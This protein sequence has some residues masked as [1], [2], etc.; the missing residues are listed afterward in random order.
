M[1][2]D[3]ALREGHAAYAYKQVGYMKGLAERFQ[4]LW[5]LPQY[6]ESVVYAAMQSE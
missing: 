1:Q 4:K 6:L 3:K 2:P 5:N